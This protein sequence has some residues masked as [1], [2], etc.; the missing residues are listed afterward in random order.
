MKTP[1]SDYR[2]C[3]QTNRTTLLLSSIVHKLWTFLSA[4][5]VPVLRLII[6]YIVHLKTEF[7]HKDRWNDSL[8]CIWQHQYRIHPW[9]RAWDLLGNTWRKVWRWAA[10][11]HNQPKSPRTK[12]TITIQQ[13]SSAH[14]HNNWLLLLLYKYPNIYQ[15]RLFQLLKHNICISRKLLYSNLHLTNYFYLRCV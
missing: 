1:K 15:K 13:K 4:L 9:S 5:W 3:V 2:Y 11:N 12:H 8:E 14:S 7:L 10:R 6:F